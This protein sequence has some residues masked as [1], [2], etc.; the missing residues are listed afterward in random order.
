MHAYVPNNI[1]HGSGQAA[2]ATIL[3]RLRSLPATG[4]LDD[5]DAAK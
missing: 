4:Y 3:M 2:E 1:I 5:A